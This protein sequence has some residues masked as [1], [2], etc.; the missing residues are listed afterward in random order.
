MLL[1]AVILSLFFL[2]TFNVS[3]CIFATQIEDPDQNEGIVFLKDMLTESIKVAKASTKDKR[4]VR[5]F[6]D[7]VVDKF[8]LEQMAQTALG[9][10]F[11]KLSKEQ[12]NEFKNHLS[13]YFIKTY[14]TQEK[15]DLFA[16]I[17]LNKAELKKKLSVNSKKNQMTIHSTF[18]TKSGDVNTKFVLIKNEKAFDIFDILIEDI[19]LLQNT[20][21]QLSQIQSQ[22][23]TPEVFLKT[24]EMASKID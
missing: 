8:A 12:F 4:S 15:V 5:K 14:A 24:F 20:R 16:S 6:A 23:K 19:G 17:D 1:K 11:K 13:N 21:D 7:I 9:P 22:S 18:K 10:Y 2:V 3:S